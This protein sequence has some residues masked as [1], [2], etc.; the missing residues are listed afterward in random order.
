MLHYAPRDVDVDRHA[1]E[2]PAQGVE[3]QQVDE[4]ARHKDYADRESS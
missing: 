1:V 2:R 4:E 3:T